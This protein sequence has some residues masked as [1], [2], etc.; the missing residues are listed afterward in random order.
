MV[1]SPIVAIMV[2]VQLASYICFL[3][4]PHI[5]LIVLLLNNKNS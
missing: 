3:E 1:I 4:L 2:H 5:E